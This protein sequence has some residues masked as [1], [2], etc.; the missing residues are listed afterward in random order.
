MISGKANITNYNRTLVEVSNITRNFRTTQ[1]VVSEGVS[2]LGYVVR[3]DRTSKSFKCFYPR[4]AQAVAGTGANAITTPVLTHANTAVANHAALAHANTAVANH[5][6]LAHAN[7]GGNAIPQPADHALDGHVVTQP[8]NHTLDAHVVTQP[9]NHS[10][11]D[12]TVPSGFRS[13][14]DAAAGSE[15]ANDVNVGEINFTAYGYR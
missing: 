4:A 12:C 15:V 9:S 6:N 10:A 7:T 5:A 1:N 2:T 8:S 14:V 11:G 3:W 13:A